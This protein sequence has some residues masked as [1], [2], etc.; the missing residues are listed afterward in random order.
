MP[1]LTADRALDILPD[2]VDAMVEKLETALLLAAD[3][4]LLA[5]VFIELHELL[6]LDFALLR[7]EVI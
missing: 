1:E 7:F 6:E 5:A 3:A 4:A 2:T